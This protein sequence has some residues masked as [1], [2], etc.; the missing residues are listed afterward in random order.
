MKKRKINVKSSISPK[1]FFLLEKILNAGLPYFEVGNLQKLS[2]LSRE[3][4][5]KII[6]S[7]HKKKIIKRIE[8][9]KYSVEVFGS[10]ANPLALAS[11]SVWPSYISFWSALSVYKF[12]EQLPETIFIA[13]TK[14]KQDIQRKELRVKYVTLSKKRF[15]GYK[16]EGT[17]K[18]RIIIAEKEKALID[19][20]F[21]PRHAGGLSET[22]K[23]L[24]NAWSELNQKKLAGYCLRMNNKSLNKRLGYLIEL[25]DLKTE[26]TILKKLQKRIGRGYSKLDST[27]PKSNEYNKKWNLI[28]NNKKLL[29]WREIH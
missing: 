7:L 5:Y 24:F 17:K 10:Y 6:Y 16:F 4:C 28:I 1:E 14:R 22:T 12:T 2:G 19:S 11:F 27:L 21:L 18:E 20:L 3:E 23:A 13:T 9:G 29:E 8:G 15:F 26:P 25:L